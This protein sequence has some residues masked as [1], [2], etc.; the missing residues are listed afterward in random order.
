MS[1]NFPIY[2]IMAKYLLEPR[3]AHTQNGFVP[4]LYA[5]LNHSGR[6][7]C[8]TQTESYTHST[9]TYTQHAHT[10]A[11]NYELCQKMPLKI[12]STPRLARRPPEKPSTQ[13]V[14]QSK[15]RCS[16]CFG[17]GLNWVVRNTKSSAE[18]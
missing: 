17:K 16:Q 13:L 9:Q 15:L 10:E 14:G 1:T 2:I 18:Q 4:P 7:L 6:L 3:V 12:L 5:P 11:Q 8:H